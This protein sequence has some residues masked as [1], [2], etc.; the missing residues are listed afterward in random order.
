MCRL[1]LLDTQDK[2][3]EDEAHTKKIPPHRYSVTYDS[4]SHV[5]VLTQRVGSVWPRVLPYCIFNV[6]F[7]VA[8]RMMKDH[9]G[10]LGAEWTRAYTLGSTG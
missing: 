3:W 7:M 10:D 5:A 6:I 9:G 4:E 2:W 1:S 8:L